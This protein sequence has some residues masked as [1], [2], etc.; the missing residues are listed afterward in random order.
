MAT[1]GSSREVFITET[2]LLKERA[3]AE[4]R[5]ACRATGMRC[6][7]P[8]DRRPRERENRKCETRAAAC[9]TDPRMCFPSERT[10]R[11]RT[12][13]Q[14]TPSQVPALNFR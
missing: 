14:A 9:H 1:A 11:T 3:D 10:R 12:P 7:S 2:A 13:A 6:G 8:R 5:E 4:L